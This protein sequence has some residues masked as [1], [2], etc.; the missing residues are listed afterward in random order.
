MRKYHYHAV[1]NTYL[2]H[3]CFLFCLTSTEDDVKLSAKEGI[4]DQKSQNR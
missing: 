4:A 2:G 3:A 1:M